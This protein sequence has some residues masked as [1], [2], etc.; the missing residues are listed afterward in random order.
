[1]K[2]LD[3]MSPDN[4][5][6]ALDDSGVRRTIECVCNPQYPYRPLT[7]F[8]MAHSDTHIYIDFFVRCNFLR[9]VN[10]ETNTP[11]YEDSAVAAM[12]QPNPSDPTF[13]VLTFNCIGTISGLEVRSGQEPKPIAPDTLAHIQR[14]ASC[15]SRPFREVEGLFTWNILATIPFDVL[16]ICEDSFPYEIKG[17]FYKCA[18][19]TSQPHFLS[20]LPIEGNFPLSMQSDKFGRIILD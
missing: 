7:T 4:V 6:T 18:T 12:F 15:G 10:Y 5:I 17:N 2:E 16:G 19:G 9:A 1:M 3:G 13:Y 20:W 11:V 14:V 8:A